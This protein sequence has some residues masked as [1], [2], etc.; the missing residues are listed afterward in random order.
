MLK[1]FLQQHIPLPAFGGTLEFSDDADDVS[2]ASLLLM[3]LVFFVP[4]LPN[5]GKSFWSGFKLNF[6]WFV[7]ERL[8]GRVHF[9]VFQHGLF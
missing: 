9:L 8:V 2:A 6:K 5:D 1:C 3:S 4:I 7:E